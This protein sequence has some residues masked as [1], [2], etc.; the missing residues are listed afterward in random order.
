VSPASPSPGHS[1]LKRVVSVS[2]GSKTRDHRF[3]TDFLG[4]RLLIERIGTDG[5]LARANALLRELD[6]TVDA[7]G[8][9][10]IALYLYAGR[11][12]YLVR[13]AARMVRG[14]TRTPIV[15]GGAI[16]ESWERWMITDYLPQR[17]GIVFRGANVLLVPAVDR[18][19]MTE[20]FLAVGAEVL[21]GDLIFGL[22][23][24][25]PV[26]S[27]AI[28]RFLAAILMPILSKVP[29]AALYPIGARQEETTPR[30][31]KYYAWADVIAGDF[32]YIR[33]H[34]P[35]DLQGKTV[36]TQSITVE[37]VELLRRRRVRRLIVDFPSMGGR[38][39]ATNVL[40]AAVVAATGRRPEEITHQEYVEYLL[41][42]GMEPRVEELTPAVG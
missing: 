10:G 3:E 37:D 20:A 13:D 23:L 29:Y 7:L 22:G 2:L 25:I 42:A 36:V 38:S 8:L 12:R 11:R 35:S 32:H 40:H 21:A 15:D 28:G 26:R 6:G 34:L 16:K 18:V 39:F 1:A 19:G 14:V 30:Y 4:Q 24:P 31:E 5:D 27:P 33:R 41:A 9:G 17:R